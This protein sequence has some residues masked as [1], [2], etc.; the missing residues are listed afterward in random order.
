MDITVSSDIES[1]YLSLVRNI[2]EDS[3]FRKLG[4]Y[5]QHLKTTRLMHSINVSYI[6]WQLARRFG[7]D[8][9]AA[10]RA[11]LLHDFFLYGYGETDKRDFSSCMAFDHPKTAAR[12]SEERFGISE[13]ERLAILSHMFPLGPLPTSREA[14]II[15]CADK[16]CATME[17]FQVPIALSRHNRVVVAAAS[18]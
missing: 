17:F 10:A 1:E 15:S 18:F 5:T 6:S 8:E 3:E 14:W 2:L 9:C 4:L 11:G 12:N 7:L 13:K 16:L